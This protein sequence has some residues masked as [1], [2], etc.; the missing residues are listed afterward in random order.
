MQGVGAVRVVPS[1]PLGAVGCNVGW[2]DLVWSLSSSTQGDLMQDL[3]TPWGSVV[4]VS[5]ALTSI[6]ME[7]ELAG[8]LVSLFA[9]FTRLFT[10]GCVCFSP[11]SI[12]VL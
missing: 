11:R 1:V 6:T 5:S 4:K 8:L 7:G 3:P 10:S 2:W 9:W 12:L